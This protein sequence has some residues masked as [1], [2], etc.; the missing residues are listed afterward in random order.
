MFANMLFNL[1]SSNKSVNSYLLSGSAWS[2]SGK[3][4]SAILM[5]ILNALL[6]RMLSPEAL[7]AYFLTFSFAS[8]ATLI[9]QFGLGQTA[10]RLISESMVNEQT[11]K[12]KV[13]V[14]AIIRYGAIGAVIV[15]SIIYLGIGK[16][17]SLHVFESEMI[18]KVTGLVAVWVIVMTFQV[19]MAEIYRGFQD[20]HL[21]SIFSG[22]LNS[23][24]A[25]ILYT[26]LWV[27]QG[28]S[29]LGQIILLTIIAGVANS[30]IASLILF[31][32]IKGIQLSTQQENHEILN[33][34]F[35]ILI[36]N[37]TLLALTQTDIWILGAMRY[38]NEVAIYCAARKIVILV[39]MPL[40]IANAFLPP[41]IAK[42]NKKN[43]KGKLEKVVR[44]TATLATLPAILMVIMLTIFGES[45]LELLYGSYYCKGATILAILCVGQ[46]ANVYSGSS[47]I[48]LIMTGNQKTMMGVTVFCGFVNIFGSIF[49]VKIY[50]Y[51]G[52]AIITTASLILQNIMMLL[53]SKRKVG[54]WTHCKF[55]VPFTNLS[56]KNTK[57]E[58]QY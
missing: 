51:T 17:L 43:K 18:Q 55:Y 46:L 5:L 29:N 37:L 28:Y 33:I 24:I 25:A 48:T 2:F 42:L 19:L 14:I 57:Y 53:Y 39:G 47:G 40:V 54:I 41:L 21:A 34:A 22:P 36:T 50:G 9:A 11:A 38:Q 44:T 32:R 31:K 12:A 10:V 8:V 30:I 6:A 23:I 26:T 27:I 13:V 15:A 49:V 56:W 20:I 52:I 45:V 16:W 58:K 35:P 1:S 3:L 7:G 4:L